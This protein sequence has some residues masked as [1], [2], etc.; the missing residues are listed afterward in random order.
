MKHRL[1]AA[2]LIALIAISL[3]GC[4]YSHEITEMA[5]AVALGI[6]KEEGGI[7][8]SVQFAKPLSISGGS[9]GGESA[10]GSSQE[11]EKGGAKNKNTTVL[12]VKGKDIFTALTAAENN[13][14]KEINLSHIKLLLFSQDVAQDGI[15]DYV[16][17]FMKSSQFSPNTY[18]AISLCRAE[19][20]MKTA[21]PSLEINPAKYYTLL[22]S[23]NDNNYMPS[24]TLRELYFN[25]SANGEGEVL[26][27]ANL[28]NDESNEKSKSG[29]EGYFAGELSVG[30][31]NEADVSGMAILSGGKLKQ[32]L[33]TKDALYYHMLTGKLREIYFLIPSV[34][35]EGQHITLRLTQDRKPKLC[36][37]ELG[38]NP[39]LSAKVCL[40]GELV[41][42]S[43]SD[44]NE[45]GIDGINELA[46]RYIEGQLTG[47]LEYTKN[48]SGADVTGFG[49]ISKMSFSDWNAWSSYNWQDKF[50]RS[51]FSV[52]AN[53]NITREGLVYTG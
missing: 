4:R 43:D 17:Q 8:V 40:T 42:C 48:E 7:A 50:I 34:K 23:N 31:E 25:L 19:E 46:S 24:T 12:T 39:K 28:S 15:S 13:L 52:T 20:Y 26:P 36:A 14:S 5:Y 45:L 11:G 27:V 44:F 53:V 38:E 6:D 3:G 32:V 1:F 35:E 49:E 22:F 33:S 29:E 51:E 47:F 10:G 2:T 16:K 37:Q 9:G 21:N 18:T 41:K 30:G